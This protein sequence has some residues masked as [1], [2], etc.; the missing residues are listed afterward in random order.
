MT[1]PT[2]H[3]LRTADRSDDLARARKLAARK[4]NEHVKLVSTSVNAVALTTLGASILLP[5]I[6]GTA[7]ARPVVWL[8]IA[9]ALHLVAHAS[10]RMLRS[11]D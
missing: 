10:V 6:S 1:F 8:L 9:G 5:G 3:D 4:F 7:V 2:N 11:E